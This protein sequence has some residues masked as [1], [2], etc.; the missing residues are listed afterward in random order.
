ML[1]NTFIRQVAERKKDKQ[2]ITRTDKQRQTE[3][4]TIIEPS[5]YC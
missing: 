4:N 1:M 2:Y 3:G 5:L